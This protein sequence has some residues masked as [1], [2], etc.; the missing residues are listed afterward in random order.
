[1]PL[2]VSLDLFKLK[3]I[4]TYLL[5][6]RDPSRAISYLHTALTAIPHTSPESEAAHQHLVRLLRAHTLARPTPPSLL[7]GVLE[8]AIR[9]FPSNTMLLSLYLAGE[10]HGRVYGRVHTLIHQQ[11][12]RGRG[13]AGGGGDDASE[14]VTPVTALWAVWA[15]AQMAGPRFWDA[16]GGA[17]RVRSVFRAA[18]E[19]TRCVEKVCACSYC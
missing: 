2:F 10:A 5:F 17:E 12:L 16:Q 19:M 13:G 7:R 18:L 3:S 1:M 11:L 9:L 4:L 8:D 6:D 14:Q 15:E